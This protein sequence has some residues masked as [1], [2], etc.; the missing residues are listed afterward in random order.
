[1]NYLSAGQDPRVMTIKDWYVV[2]LITMIPLVNL[3]VL[4]YWAIQDPNS[5]K[6][7]SLIAYSSV[8]LITAVISMVIFFLFAGSEIMNLLE[9]LQQMQ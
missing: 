9:R 6:K 5:Y 7:P 1:M 8:S 4:T 3:I 2:S